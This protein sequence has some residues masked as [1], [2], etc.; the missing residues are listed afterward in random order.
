MYEIKDF[1]CLLFI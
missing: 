1:Y